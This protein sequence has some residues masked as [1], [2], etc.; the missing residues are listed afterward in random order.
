MKKIGV[1]IP[2][3]NRK[4]HLKTV[5]DCVNAQ[6]T[7]G[8]HLEIIVVVDGSTDGTLEMLE[9][10]YPSVHIIKGNGNWWFTKSLN[11]GC[12][13]AINHLKSDL[14]LTLNDDVEFGPN[15]FENIITDYNKHRD[16]LMGS[17]SVDRYND[18]IITFSGISKL[19]KITGSYVQYYNKT[20]KYNKEKHF[21]VFE[22]ITLPTRGLLFSKD[23][24]LKINGFDQLFPQYASDYDFVLRAKRYGFTSYISHN[25]IIN[26]KTDL[27]GDGSPKH[28][29]SFPSFIYNMFFNKYSP[30]YYLKNLRMIWRHRR[31]KLLFPFY[32]IVGL[33]ATIRSYYKYN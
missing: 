25:A 12:D 29:K 18:N 8:L 7:E 31:P 6:N 14:I 1:I 24:F 30:A 22:S 3:H 9:N 33:L 26:E 32:S 20:T 23:V 13:F 17:L 4:E 5:L 28:S 11:K 21:G 16:S 27:T 2:T 15:Y 19:K 10:N